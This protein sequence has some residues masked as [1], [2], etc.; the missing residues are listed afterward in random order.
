MDSIPSSGSVPIL[1]HY[2]TGQAA[3]VAI[4]AAAFARA[5]LAAHRAFLE[6]GRRLVDAR[7]ACRPGEWGRFL[8]AAGL[9]GRTAAD[10]MM[11]S[12][13]GASAERVTDLGG[14]R[15]ALE[16]LRGAAAGAVEA[17]DDGAMASGNDAAAS[18][19]RRRGRAGIV[20]VTGAGGGKPA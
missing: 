18:R 8:A 19:G 11:L 3:D 13:S 14:V 15:A 17:A 5:S 16:S 4:E 7:G 6:A 12:R 1:S 20:D 9:D 10:M 2:L